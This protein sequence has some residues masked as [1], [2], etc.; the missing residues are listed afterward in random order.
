MNL[1]LSEVEDDEFYSLNGCPRCEIGDR[2]MTMRKTE[3]IE[4]IYGAERSIYECE[5]CGVL[6]V[7][8]P[9]GWYVI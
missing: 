2:C 6:A 7:S 1:D 3:E 8:L 4:A 5:A 9:H